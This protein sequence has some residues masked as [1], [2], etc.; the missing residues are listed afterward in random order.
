VGRAVGHAS[1]PPTAQKTLGAL[2]LLELKICS[3]FFDCSPLLM[4]LAV[5]VYGA[6]LL[7][8]KLGACVNR[9]ELVFQSF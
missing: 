3:F 2:L 1:A 9:N 5:A 8:E 4:T 6:L 7:H